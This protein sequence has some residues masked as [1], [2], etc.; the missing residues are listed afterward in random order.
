MVSSRY[1]QYEGQLVKG[2]V[3]AA[4][5]DTVTPIKYVFAPGETKR[6]NTGVKFPRGMPA[7]ALIVLRSSVQ[8]VGLI[9]PSIGVIDKD[10]KDYIFITL[11]N[12]TDRHV[13]IEKNKRIAQIVFFQTVEVLPI[14]PIAQVREM[15]WEKDERADQ[16]EEQKEGSKQLTGVNIA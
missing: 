16:R 14:K 10:Y 4:G 9:Q 8:D 3:D 13:T 6:L 1:A 7:P 11:K 5:W 12:D 2:T 15:R